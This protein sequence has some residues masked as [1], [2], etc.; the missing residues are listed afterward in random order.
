M[1]DRSK[2]FQVK[3]SSDITDTF[4]TT[5]C[6]HMEKYHCILTCQYKEMSVYI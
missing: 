6:V 1:V 3:F 4:N 2:N 5:Y